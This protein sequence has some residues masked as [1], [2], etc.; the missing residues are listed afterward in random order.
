M[1]RKDQNAEHIIFKTSVNW[2]LLTFFCLIC[3]HRKECVSSSLNKRRWVYCYSWLEFWVA[4]RI[5]DEIFSVLHFMWQRKTCFES[6]HGISLQSRQDFFH[7]SAIFSSEHSHRKKVG[8]HLEFFRQRKTGEREKVL[9]RGWI[10]GKRKV[11]GGGRPHHLTWWS[12][13]GKAVMLTHGNKM[14]ALEAIPWPPK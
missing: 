4:Y 9:P 10:I 12:Q 13:G 5:E 3:S 6:L 8:H 1:Q 11:R 14:P 2:S 7:V